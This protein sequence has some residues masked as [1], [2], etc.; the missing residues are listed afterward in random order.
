M[1]RVASRDHRI[2]TGFAVGKRLRK[3][4]MAVVSEAT[5]Q[6]SLTSS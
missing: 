4:F 2:P 1:R 5:H 6:S 3:E